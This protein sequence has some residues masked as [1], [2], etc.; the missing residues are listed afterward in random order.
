[1]ASEQDASRVITRLAGLID[2]AAGALQ[3]QQSSSAVSG[4]GTSSQTAAGVA[5]RTGQG[6]TVGS[7]A[8]LEVSVLKAT[9]EL[10][11]AQQ[12]LDGAVLKAPISGTVG[13]VGVTR[14]ERAGTSSA[15][16][17]VGPGSAVI[18]VDLPLAHLGKV[19]VAQPVVVTPAGTTDQLSGQVAS[20][21]VLPTSTTSSSPTYPVA[22]TVSDAPVTLASGA[23]A[24]ASITLA[25]ATDVLTVP[26]SAVAGVS[27]GVAA[28]KVLSGTTETATRVTLGAIGDGLAQVADGLTKGQVV[29]LA[30]PSQ[31]LPTG[32]TLRRQRSG[33]S[34]LTGGGPG[35]TTFG[36]SR[37]G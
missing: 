19:R 32:D 18:T 34:S 37:G 3:N 28:V 33:V 4:S 21:S 25:T 35:R 16:V 29:V 1:M 17:I 24:G 7:T 30:D 5:A 26:V 14:G 12:N 10:A 36:R 11:T 8:G 13:S 6:G 15:I 20:I 9:Q 2:K 22:I 23:Q 31:P 27:A